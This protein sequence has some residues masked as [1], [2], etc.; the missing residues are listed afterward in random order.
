MKTKILAML[1]FVAASM[2][3][4]S[5]NWEPTVD[6]TVSFASMGIEVSSAMDVVNSR[7]E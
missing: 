5:E 2:A 6:G 7:A 3:S 4:C 1:A